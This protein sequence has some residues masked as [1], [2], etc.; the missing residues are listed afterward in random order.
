MTTSSNHKELFR[1]STT[2]DKLTLFQLLL[3]ARMLT[4][5]MSLALL[6]VIHRELSADNEY[7]RSIYKNYA[8]SIAA[9]RYYMA[10]VLQHVVDAWK[11]K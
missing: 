1:A 9:L 4:A 10:D 7:D 3:D 11:R 2:R 5:D 6:K 8:A